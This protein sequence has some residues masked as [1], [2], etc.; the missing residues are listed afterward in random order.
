M[1]RKAAFKS[2]YTLIFIIIKVT[3]VSG[4]QYS[5]ICDYMGDHR[6][7][8]AVRGSLIYTRVATEFCQLC[9]ETF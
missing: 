2:P 6:R 5:R 8:H 4:I 9:T 7:V 3:S 1:V